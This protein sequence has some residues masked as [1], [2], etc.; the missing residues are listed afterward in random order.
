MDIK[1]C[2]EI[3]D[4]D[5]NASV[6][7]VQQQFRDLATVWHPDRFYVQWRDHRTEGCGETRRW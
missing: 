6:K 5:P 2:Y 3:L 4:L 7:D 1:K